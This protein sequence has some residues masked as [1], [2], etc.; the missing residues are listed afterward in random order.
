MR[1]LVK[2]MTTSDRLMKQ[3]G[4]FKSGTLKSSDFLRFGNERISKTS[5]AMASLFR[6]FSSVKGGVKESAK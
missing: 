5:P 2:K 3:A 6:S 4:S 1:I